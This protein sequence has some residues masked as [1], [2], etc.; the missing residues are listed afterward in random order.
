[1]GLRRILREQHVNERGSGVGRNAVERQDF[2][3]AELIQQRRRDVRARRHRFEVAFLIRSVAPRSALTKDLIVK[4]P[5]AQL[6]LFPHELIANAELPARCA[7]RQ[8]LCG[9]SQRLC[10]VA[11]KI[12]EIENCL[13]IQRRRECRLPRNA[14]QQFDVAQR[15]DERE[16]VVGR[17]GPVDPICDTVERNADV[18]ARRS[19]DDPNGCGRERN[20]RRRDDRPRF[21]AA[22]DRAKAVG[23]GQGAA[24]PTKRK[25]GVSAGVV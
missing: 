5:R 8:F 2:F 1:M 15:S 11:G 4:I 20:Q 24:V 23:D 9:I 6:L 21:V 10:D 22:F 18:L 7:G 16:L 13:C 12:F 25:D 17:K 3:N 19:G 14:Y